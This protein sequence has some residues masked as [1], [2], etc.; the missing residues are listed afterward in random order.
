MVKFPNCFLAN[1]AIAYNNT[2]MTTE[3]ELKLRLSPQN[4][5]D[6]SHALVNFLNQHAEPDGET[7]LQNHYYDSDDAA[8]ASAK[9]ALRIRQKGDHFE[10]TLKTAGSSNGGMHQRREWNWPLESNA[11]NADVL[12]DEEVQQ[13]WPQNLN[14]EQLQ[15][16]FA[17][18]FQRRAWRWTLE[19]NGKT[20]TAEVV[21][22][23]GEIRSGDKTQPLCELELELLDGDAAGLWA[24]AQQLLPH[25]PLW[26]SDISKAERGY[27]LSGIGVRWADNSASFNET[28]PLAQAVPLWLQHHLLLFKR[29][30]EKALWEGDS[31]ASLE[32]WQHWLALRHLPQW[33][34]KIIKR[35]DTK[36][37]RQALDQL[38]P[39]LETLS[40]LTTAQR[41]FNDAGLRS[42]W[43]ECAQQLRDSAE[44][45]QALLAIAHWSYDQ[46]PRL[47]QMAGEAGAA[48]EA[49][50]SGETLSHY[51][52]RSWK[53]AQ[54]TL[55]APH[56]SWHLNQ[57]ADLQ[58]Q[59]A[60]LQHL[61]LLRHALTGETGGAAHQ[62]ERRLLADIV[63]GQALVQNETDTLTQEQQSQLHEA[64][65]YE[66]WGRWLEFSSAVR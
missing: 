65:P 18:H 54:Q 25:T 5:N 41:F 12:A 43:L 58:S 6:P 30:L 11:L 16:V 61:H 29:T 37:L 14:I 26:I 50:V 1:L 9:A 23:L 39:G 36:E 8:L 40:A 24:M 13:H 7:L 52:H 63:N 51:F 55:A 4:L 28:M 56:E 66:L 2:A 48:V 42:R 46:L 34:G 49:G 60:R 32:C 47:Q 62:R 19:V 22:D 44:L 31:Q 64:L 20:T 35:K 15:P 45:A 27:G 10:Q 53:E 17:T 38:Q 3:I 57:W 59:V 21:I 33:C